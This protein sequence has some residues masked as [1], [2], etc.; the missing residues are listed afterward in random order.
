MKQSFGNRMISLLFA[1][2]LLFLILTAAIS[3]PIYLRPFYY[4]HIDAM[5][6]SALSGFPK[7]EIVRSYDAVLD[8][9]TLPGHA[10]GTGVMAHS[11]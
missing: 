10:F 5:D 11:P 3:L 9:L 6:L 4:A 2:L 8:Y 1:V 7:E